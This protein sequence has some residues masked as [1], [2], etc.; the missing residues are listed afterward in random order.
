MSILSFAV[1]GKDLSDFVIESRDQAVFIRDSFRK[2]SALP[3]P[4][5]SSIYAAADA[6]RPGCVRA[7]AWFANQT[8]MT[9]GNVVKPQL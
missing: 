2:R 4:L 1:S 7:K 6:S 8:T 3:E 9:I 5:L